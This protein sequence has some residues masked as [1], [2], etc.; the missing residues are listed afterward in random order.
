MTR[1]R[2]CA[3]ETVKAQEEEL[4]GRVQ[5]RTSLTS[6]SPSC[7]RSCSFC[8]GPRRESTSVTPHPSHGDLERDR[9]RDEAVERRARI[10][11]LGE[12]RHGRVPG[13]HVDAGRGGGAQLV[14]EGVRSGGAHCDVV[15]VAEALRRELQGEAHRQRGSRTAK[16]QNKRKE[17]RTLSF[18]MFSIGTRNRGDAKMRL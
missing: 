8:S 14:E 9:R 18:L 3:N 15:D 17:R 16:T 13:V 1:G 6:L 12:G 5:G 2:A 4:E 10:D 11:E 7:E